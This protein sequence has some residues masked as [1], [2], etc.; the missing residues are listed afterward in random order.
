MTQTLSITF[1]A[2]GMS[3][4][5]GVKK[6]ETVTVALEVA[7][8]ETFTGTVLLVQTKNGGQTYEALAS[9]DAAG[10][11]TITP[12][13]DVHLAFNC[14]VF[15]AE[16]D[17]IV[18]TITHVSDVMK[19]Y[20]ARDGSKPLIIKEDGVET[21]KLTATAA[22]ITAATIP[23]LTSTAATITTGTVG[24]LNVTTFH[25]GGDV[26]ISNGEG[27]PVDYTDGDPAATGEGV[28]GIGSLYID[29]TNGKIYING[30]TKAEPAW[31]IVTSA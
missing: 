1:S 27:A 26:Y 2:V 29:M 25:L 9:F 20:Q 31:K 4:L 14:T 18:C 24:T 6:G 8:E 28:M 23:A 17:D 19:E 12:D 13:S 30:G 5:L 21:P 16:S 15:D 11:A 22:T 10:T 7:A 3:S